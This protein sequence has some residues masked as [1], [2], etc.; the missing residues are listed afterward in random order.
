MEDRKIP[1]ISYNPSCDLLPVPY[2][3]S[4]YDFIRDVLM[5]PSINQLSPEKHE[6]SHFNW[7][8]DIWQLPW[9]LPHKWTMK[10]KQIT[11]GLG[12]GINSPFCCNL[13]KSPGLNKHLLK[14]S[15]WL[16]IFSW[17]TFE[18]VWI[19]IGFTENALKLETKTKKTNNT[20]TTNKQNPTKT[21][22]HLS[23]ELTK[24]RPEQ[25]RIHFKAW[26]WG[27]L[28]L[29]IAYLGMN[30][31]FPSLMIFKHF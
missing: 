8:S 7:V 19:W 15:F 6:K 28:S 29:W 9:I 30:C 4:I 2:V 20:T 5:V 13:K 11:G 24:L 10:W 22:P 16:S 18:N 21:L 27:R 14:K 17:F 1:T 23:C 26:Q 3:W 12:I 25:K 31:Y